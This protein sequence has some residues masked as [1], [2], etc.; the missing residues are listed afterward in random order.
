MLATVNS[1][2]NP[3]FYAFTNPQFQRGYR[4]V[5][6]KCGGRVKDGRSIEGSRATSSLRT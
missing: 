2:A 4:N 1:A 3:V 5:W 6:K